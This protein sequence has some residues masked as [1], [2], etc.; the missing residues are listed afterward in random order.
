VNNDEVM[1]PSLLSLGSAVMLAI[2]SILAPQQPAWN[3][4]AQDKV[5]DVRV[6]G[7]L[8]QDGKEWLLTQATDPTPNVPPKPAADKAATPAKTPPPPPGTNQ[9]KLIGVDVFHLPTRKDQRIEVTGL[10]IRAKPMD[11]IN[12]TAVVPVATTCDAPA[13]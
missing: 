10:L 3:P 5:D 11:R 13:R 4:A 8:K 9:F 6:V 2:G 12:L 1:M 7:C